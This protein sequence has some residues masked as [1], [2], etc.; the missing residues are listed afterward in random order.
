MESVY[1][2]VTWACHRA[3]A[4]C[5]DDRF[6]PYAG[7]E[8]TRLVEEGVR[9]NRKVIAS[10]PETFL[11][12][13]PARPGPDGKPGERIGRIIIGGGEVLID[14]VREQLFYPILDEIQAKYWGL[15]ARLAVETTG[16][17]LQPRFIREMTERGVWMIMIA[18]NSDFHQGI[19][20]EAR[21]GF[22]AGIRQMMRECNVSE[23]SPGESERDYI[24]EEGPFFL[25]YD[26]IPKSHI[27]E[28]WPRGRALANGL[29]DGNYAHN[30]C[31]GPF[32]ARNFL[33]VGF[34]G[35]EVAIEPNGDL[36]PCRIKTKTRL[37]NLTEER[38]LDILD[39]LRGH[40]VFEALNRGDPEAM[41]LEKGLSREAFFE[42]ASLTDPKGRFLS[43]PC[44]GCDHFF[45]KKV[46]GILDDIRAERIMKR[47]ED[48]AARL[49]RADPTAGLFD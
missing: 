20:G 9:T 7:E 36:F 11:Y 24:L 47:D 4:H 45:E 49:V 21:E 48:I 43:S 31:A 14:P 23:V 32:G 27:G 39:S 3:C 28:I 17:L 12:L 10:L 35:A 15:E 29:A 41:G 34:A 2:A 42:A 44:L 19:S 38:L 6:R 26:A 33:N 1:W 37:G 30:L 25:F 18:G 5:N 22:R 40:P 16:D 46:A 13:D 8:L